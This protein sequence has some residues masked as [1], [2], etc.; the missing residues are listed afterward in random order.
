MK[1][2]KVKSNDGSSVRVTNGH[3]IDP[4]TSV[5]GRKLRRLYKH[6]PHLFED[7]KNK[8]ATY[9]IPEVEI[10]QDI[11]KF[12]VQHKKENEY[13]TNVSISPKAVL[14]LGGVLFLI[15][16]FIINYLPFF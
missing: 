16:N 14:G 13:D 11:T 15:I 9:D 2:S 12:E 7:G 4:Q 10:K 1:R 6:K 5:T 3:Q 8:G